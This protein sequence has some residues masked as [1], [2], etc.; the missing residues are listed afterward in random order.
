MDNK[1]RNLTQRKAM[2]LAGYATQ[3]VAAGNLHT[4][5]DALNRAI[6]LVNELIEDTVEHDADNDEV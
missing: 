2:G 1:T 5:W 4:A 3:S 6:G